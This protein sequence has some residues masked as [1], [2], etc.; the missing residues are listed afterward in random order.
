MDV[1]FLEFEPC[2][3]ITP[4][5]FK[6]KNCKEEEMVFPSSIIETRESEIGGEIQGENVGHLDRPDLIAYS[7]RNRAEEAVM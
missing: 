1:V 5:P 2:F 3:S 7:R 4:S 6:G